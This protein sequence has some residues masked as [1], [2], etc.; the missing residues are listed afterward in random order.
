MT[1]LV[2]SFHDAATGTFT[3]VVHD[4]DGGHAAIVDPVLDYDPATGAMH[5]ASAERVLA[6]VAE[7][8]LQ[9]EWILETHAHADHLTAAAW[10]RERTGARVGI[11]RGIVQVQARF[12]EPLGL[13]AD[14]RA[15]GSQFDRLFDDGDEFAIGT[16]RARAM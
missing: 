3:H 2:A 11:G 14:F 8:R 12:R 16:L 5:A 9:V 10:L 4:G 6:C 1:P 7:H 13:G 15:D